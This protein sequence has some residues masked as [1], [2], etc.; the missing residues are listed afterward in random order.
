M[1]KVLITVAVIAGVLAAIAIG[2][3]F[4]SSHSNNSQPTVQTPPAATPAEAPA[5]APE[6]VKKTR[7]KVTAP[8]KEA[9]VAAV[10]PAQ[11]DPAAEAPKAE[12]DLDGFVKSLTPE[13]EQKLQMLL[14]Q[15]MMKRYREQ[16]RYQMPA[17]GR[18]MMLGYRGGEYKITEAQQQQINTIKDG[19][20]PRLDAQLAGNWSR[21]DELYNA[22][23][24][25]QQVVQSTTASDADKAAAKQ[26]L[27]QVQRELGELNQQAYQVRQSMD[28][29]YMS[30]VQA[31]L[32]PQQ[33][34]AVNDMGKGGG[35]QFFG[36]NG[37]AAGNVAP[38]R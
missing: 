22:M 35:G 31:V 9:E 8:A 1:S 15:R 26:E 28:G 10:E 6:K 23:F 11:A 2:A 27:G 30:A 5:A 37:P 38:S 4:I 13:Q 20:K 7:V 29:E 34:Q 18:L 3:V 16:Q 25:K 14:S 19:L 24:A 33:L 32:S 21:T 12:T 17:D 36:T